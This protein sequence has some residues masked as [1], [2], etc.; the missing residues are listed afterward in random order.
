MTTVK[1]ITSLFGK[2]NM[3][4]MAGKIRLK[5]W[6]LFPPNGPCLPPLQTHLSPAC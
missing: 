2:G 5:N 4:E 3:L 6:R 1:Y